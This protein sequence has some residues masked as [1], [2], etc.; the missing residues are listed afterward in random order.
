[1]NQFFLPKHTA[2][3][4]TILLNHSQNNKFIFLVTQHM[5]ECEGY[6]KTFILLLVDN[7]SIRLAN[8][9]MLFIAVL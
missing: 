8:L 6:L 1:M 7:D 2:D 4:C 3:L 5:Q 9:L